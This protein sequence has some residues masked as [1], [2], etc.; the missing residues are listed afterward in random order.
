MFSLLTTFTLFITSTLAYVILNVHSDNP[1]ING[2]GIYAHTD[3]QAPYPTY[4]YLG[5]NLEFLYNKNHEAL[6]Y[7]PDGSSDYTFSLFVTDNGT[8]AM[9]EVSNFKS[10]LSVN[11]TIAKGNGCVFFNG[12]SSLFAEKNVGSVFSEDTYALKTYPN[13]GAPAGAIPLTLIGKFST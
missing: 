1:T 10:P 13:G 2:Q 6:Y 9:Q 4:L 5:F 11:I 7:Y 3:L 12:S 8:L